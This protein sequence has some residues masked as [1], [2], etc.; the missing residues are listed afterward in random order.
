MPEVHHLRLG[1]L[2]EELPVPLRPVGDPHVERRRNN[3]PTSHIG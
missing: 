2:G 1:V 3:F